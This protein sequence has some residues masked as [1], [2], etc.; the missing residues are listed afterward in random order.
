MRI[1]I[2]PRQRT[3]MGKLRLICRLHRGSRDTVA[4]H[5]AGLALFRDLRESFEHAAVTDLGPDH[6]E[7]GYDAAAVRRARAES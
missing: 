6:F 1:T 4:E 3:Q 2:D 5:N 7:A